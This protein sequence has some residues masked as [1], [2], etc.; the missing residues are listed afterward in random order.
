MIHV[1]V[2]RN[3]DHIARVP[4]Q[5]FHFL[6]R[7]RQKRRD[8]EALGPIR[9]TREQSAHMFVGGGSERHGPPTLNHMRG[10]SNAIF[11][12]SRP[13]A[14]FIAELCRTSCRTTMSA[15]PGD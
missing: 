13:S 2:A 9:P 4:A 10:L 7:S 8:S 5:G 1:C 11:L 14:R 6:A 12:K 3:E 15:E